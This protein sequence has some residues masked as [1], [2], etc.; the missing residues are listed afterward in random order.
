MKITAFV[1]IKLNSERLPN[2]NILTLHN[3]PLSYYIFETLL[4]IKSLDSVYVFCSDA[5]IMNY[6]P[7]GVKLLL[8]DKS[9]D[10]NLTKGNEIYRAFINKIESDFYLLAHTTSPFVKQ[11][12]IEKGI[13]GVI[14]S[15]FDSSF[16]VKKHQTFAWY[17]NMPLNFSLSNVPRTQDIK[18]IFIETSSFYIFNKEQVIQNKRVGKNPLMIELNDIEAIDIDTKEDFEF[19]QQI[20]I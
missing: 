10:Q 4:K 13:N 20:K 12:S 9:L 8:R 19:A 5:T 15:I 1:P 17:D 7:K 6:L 11:E 16:S 2:K 14:S 18:P 3:K